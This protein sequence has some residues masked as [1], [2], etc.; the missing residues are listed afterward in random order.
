MW[1]GLIQRFLRIFTKS[2]RYVGLCLDFAVLIV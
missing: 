1:S 2:F